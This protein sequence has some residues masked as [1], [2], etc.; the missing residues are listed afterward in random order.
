MVICEATGT[1]L[2][3]QLYLQGK[4][5]VENRARCLA[6]EWGIP[7]A[8]ISK[9]TLS[10][11]AINLIDLEYQRNNKILPLRITNS[12]L[13]V[14]LVD[15]LQVNLMDEVRLITGYE[16]KAVVVSEEQLVKKH[17]ELF[18]TEEEP[19]VFEEPGLDS[20]VE[21][22]QM[23]MNSD[24]K[25]EA[26]YHELSGQMDEAAAIRLVNSFLLEGIQNGSSDIHIQ[27]E[28]NRTQVRYRVDGVL[29][30]GPA[31]P[32]SLMKVVAARIKVMANL[33]LASRKQPLD[34]R[35]SITFDARK[36]ELRV[37]ILPTV[38][39][40]KIV[41]R[42]A[43]QGGNLI[44]LEDMNLGEEVTRQFRDILYR[45]HGLFL[46]TGPTGSGKS[47][48]LYS[49]LA[50]LNTRERN[51]LTVENPVESQLDGVA[52]A[53]I[54]E[55]GGLGFTDCLRAAL[56]QD[57]DIIMVGEIRDYE[58][59]A[60]A[61]QASLT[62]HFVL[63]TLH[64]ND[65]ASAV[66]RL[67]DMGVQPFLIASSL[68]GV[69]AQRLVR[70][71]CKECK[72]PF[73]ASPQEIEGLPIEAREDGKVHLFRAKGCISCFNSGYSGRSGIY[74]LLTVTN[75]IQKLILDRAPDSDIRLKAI[76][77]GMQTLHASVCQRAFIGLT[78]LE[79]AH[80]VVHIG[81]H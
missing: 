34:G 78:T 76:E 81:G 1:P 37:S 42:V 5:S 60:I 50:E 3:E 72:E 44:S 23:Q 80:R 29:V 6:M 59:A 54:D 24:V 35:M 75:A 36:F 65:A 79:E 52:Q 53:E 25:G 51:I 2:A 63:S 22:V 14:G 43:E 11:D 45:P 70:R 12:V 20:M 58:T 67:A 21:D 15:P 4:L 40:P 7:Y 31:V 18:G 64:T 69:L 66:T 39:G 10:L 32:Q 9:E 73:I 13:F 30:D 56:R 8:D 47:T 27:G 62:G 55:K 16:A 17:N 28:K 49:G 74:E 71:I 68:A 46:I 26:G 41:M 61:I 33:D 77:E 38:T 57:P 19:E 48:T